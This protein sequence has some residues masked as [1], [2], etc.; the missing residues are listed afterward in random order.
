MHRRRR[1]HRHG[2]RAHL[3]DGEIAPGIFWT[4]MLAGLPRAAQD[5]PGQQVRSGAMGGNDASLRSLEME[6]RADA[7]AFSSPGR[8]ATG[9]P[10]ARR[11]PLRHRG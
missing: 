8:R 6:R 10:C 7:C 11:S 1:G 3:K 5:S 9:P 2:G 4:P